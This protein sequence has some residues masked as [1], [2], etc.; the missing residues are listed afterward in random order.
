MESWGHILASGLAVGGIAGFL[1]HRSGFCLAGAFRD[2]FLFRDAFLARNLLL[3]VVAS[4][5]LFEGARR[6]GLLPF[7]PFPL[8]GPPSAAHLGG[9]MVFG[10]GMVL[11]GGCVVGTLYKTGAGNLPAAAAILGLIAGSAA[12]AEFHPLW[13]SL[14]AAMRLPVDA[15]T[16]PLLLAVDPG[17]VVFAI[18]VPASFLFARWRREGKWSRRGDLPRGYVPP[19]AAA[20]ALA[21]L[22]TGYCSLTGMPIGITTS[23]SK[24]AGWVESLLAPRHFESLA[25]FRSTPLSVVHPGTG[26]LLL[27]GPGPAPDYISAVQ[28]P[29]IAGILL[30]GALSAVLVSELTFRRRIPAV[31]LLAGFSGGVLMALSSRLGGGCNAWHLLGGV[32]ILALPSLLFA[33]G[34]FPGAWVGGRLM[35]KIL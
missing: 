27:G 20:F 18:A 10:V 19:W 2:V 16:F 30:G 15:V 23:Y 8:L 5:V 4:M 32:P 6:L 17:I 21:L 1:M 25:F 35:A 7:H 34:L 12:Y 28:L 26:E 31:Q 29:V 33:A 13:S 22:G 14:R 24:M 9:G 11:A 3:A